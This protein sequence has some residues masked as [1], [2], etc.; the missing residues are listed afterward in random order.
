MAYGDFWSKASGGEYTEC[1]EWKAASSGNGYGR[2]QGEA[3][4]RHSYRLMVGEIPDGLQLDHLCGNR[5]CVNPWHLEP[6]TAA[7]NNSRRLHGQT[8]KTSCHR[9]HAFTDENTWVDKRGHRHCRRC[10]RERSQQQY[11]NNR[12]AGQRRSRD[13]QRRLRQE[14]NNSTTTESRRTS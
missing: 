10:N 12:E 7:V 3:A 11:R 4:H 8:A 6:V 5:A 2:F 14:R 9:G 13:Y 1:W